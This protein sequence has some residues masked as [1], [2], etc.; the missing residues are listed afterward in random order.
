MANN[1][2]NLGIEKKVNVDKDFDHYYDMY[3]SKAEEQGYNG[4]IKV[5]KE[6]GKI[7]FYVEL[8]Y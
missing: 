1:V 7:I 4:D 5:L 3:K 8:E 6:H 2:R